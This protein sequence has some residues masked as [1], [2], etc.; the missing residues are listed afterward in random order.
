MKNKQ[1]I[2]QIHVKYKRE[3]SRHCLI[4]DFKKFSKNVSSKYL[5]FSISS[6]ECEIKSYLRIK[7]K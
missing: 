7:Q 3:N 5:C 1:Q 2:Y 6:K 4:D